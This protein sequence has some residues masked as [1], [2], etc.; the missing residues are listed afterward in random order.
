M[1]I[2]NNILTV[3]VILAL[4]FFLAQGCCTPDPVIDD[5]CGN[6]TCGINEYCNNGYCECEDSTIRFGRDCT[7]I[8]DDSYI[9]TFNDSCYCLTS[10]IIRADMQ[11][12][13]SNA[14]SIFADFPDGS[15]TSSSL[16][17]GFYQKKPDGDSILTYWV[18]PRCRVKGIA[19]DSYLTGKFI[20]K[21]SLVARL[22][23]FD[24]LNFTTKLD[25]CDI[26]FVKINK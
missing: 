10:M 12:F 21:D 15:Q 4:G 6:V 5:P 7:R 11:Q 17:G 14:Y 3:I 2:K 1:K 20:G 16:T 26:T 18:T 9:G 13:S 25:S 22:V 19:A 8:F 24:E 23:W